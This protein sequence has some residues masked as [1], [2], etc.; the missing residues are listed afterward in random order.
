MGVLCMCDYLAIRAGAS[1]V[2]PSPQARTV[3]L[4][5]RTG[6][7][8]LRGGIVFGHSQHPSSL[9]FDARQ[10]GLRR[11]LFFITSKQSAV[12]CAAGGSAS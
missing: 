12:Q 4:E 8:H 9:R 11:T 3:S 1:S 10:A 2:R 6:H 5:M 7:P